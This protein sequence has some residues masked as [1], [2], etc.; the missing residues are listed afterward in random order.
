M[1]R[2]LIYICCASIILIS[3]DLFS[4]AKIEELK[5]SLENEGD[6][7]KRTK[8]YNDIIFR[9]K[10]V[11]LDSALLYAEKAIAYY[12]SQGDIANSLYYTIS[13]A[14]CYRIMG[15]C[16]N[17]SS[18]VENILPQVREHNINKLENAYLELGMG[19]FCLSQM[20]SALY[21]MHL[22]D[23]SCRTHGSKKCGDL[24]NNIA[25]IHLEVGQYKEAYQILAKAKM[26]ANFNN[27]INSYINQSQIVKVLP[28]LNKPEEWLLELEELNKMKVD[29]GFDSLAVYHFEELK[30]ENLSPKE[31]IAFL[32]RAL[33]LISKMGRN[34]NRSNLVK[35][36][37][38][39]YRAEKSF[40][41]M[42][43]LVEDNYPSDHI[44]PHT[45]VTLVDLYAEMLKD[46][47]NYKEALH[48]SE[49]NIE[50]K[51]SLNDISDNELLF[52]L[53]EKYDSAEK[54]REITENRMT[55]QARTNQRNIFLS[56]AIAL[57]LLSLLAF[58]RFRSK[59]KLDAS[60]ISHLEKE[61]K[62]L[63][64]NA[65]L[66]GQEAERMRIAKDLHDGLGG[67]LSS[68]K[69][70][71]SKIM[72]EVSKIESFSIYEKTTAMVDEACDEVRRI[73]H[74]LLPGSLSLSGLKTAIEQLGEEL[75]E[76][77]KFNI[78]TEVIGYEQEIDE[79]TEVFIYR[80][81]QE[82]INNIVRHAE[83]KNVLIQLTETADEY[84]ITIEDDGQG[85]DTESDF[86][87]IGLKSIRSR[88]D[89]LK[90]EMDL[91]SNLG[92]GSTVTVHIP[93]SRDEK[94][95]ENT[96]R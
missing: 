21:Y 23:E 62:I 54:E 19:H 51:D 15:K 94:S 31:N 46:Q 83:A 37:A 79:T 43:L 14:T 69:A 32:E 5:E 53:Q 68:V 20:D 29:M 65:M 90:G 12:H 8:L 81:I 55:I 40:E 92:V 84:H 47:S 76:S 6:P 70:R 30:F 17:S 44:Y 96:N 57:L 72:T 74:N 95:P 33:K 41:K 66:E 38:F 56:S 11:S 2:F 16:E 1:R 18:I 48:W 26:D 22:A 67:L 13:S 86:E 35:A 93:K 25:G 52:E 59:Q 91:V 77:H 82:S 34:T 3:G 24:A 87:G 73:S 58:T 28:L 64:M 42:K 78:K 63:T 10:V 7:K 39:E 60:R 89:F 88:A 45:K 4:S 50:L 75:N 71:L 27:E 85:F 49:L 61:K 36:L 80:I 9:Y